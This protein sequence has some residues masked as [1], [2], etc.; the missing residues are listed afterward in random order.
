MSLAEG[1][2]Q[3]VKPSIGYNSSRI[4]KQYLQQQAFKVI[5]SN[6]NLISKWPE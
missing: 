2:E 5:M 4:L 6:M 3:F 1:F